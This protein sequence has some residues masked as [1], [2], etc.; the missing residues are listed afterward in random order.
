MKLG[1][2]RRVQA[3]GAKRGIFKV[4]GPRDPLGPDYTVD[5][6]TGCWL[7]KWATNTQG[8]GM[9]RHKGRFAQVIRRVKRV[10]KGQVVRHSGRCVS[11]ACINPK[12]LTPGTHSEN[13]RDMQI[14]GTANFKRRLT[15]RE[16]AS[17]RRQAAKGGYGTQSKLAR[18]FG[19]SQS[20]IRRIVIGET[21]SWNLEDHKRTRNDESQ[22][23][24][25]HRSL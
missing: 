6:E 22:A 16:A 25:S 21:Y 7:W 17:I 10:R 14:D 2:E 15:D 12:H 19:C 8:Y 20:T 3:T 9:V 4:R 13:M 18:K 23:R 1:I 24:C 5:P 11:R